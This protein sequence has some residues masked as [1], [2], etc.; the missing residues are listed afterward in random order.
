MRKCKKLKSSQK[1]GR[2]GQARHIF[3]DDESPNI[4]LPLTVKD[5]PAHTIPN[6]PLPPDRSG[7]YERC[8]AVPTI[9]SQRSGY[10]AS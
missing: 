9:G 6:T 4:Q 8:Q 7:F 3:V 5:A 10:G 2:A 1:C